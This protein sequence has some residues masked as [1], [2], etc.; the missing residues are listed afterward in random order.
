MGWVILR[1]VLFVTK[2]IFFFNV[3]KLGN[4]GDKSS[5][6]D[7]KYVTYKGLLCSKV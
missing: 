4:I 3:M 6:S 5:E 1:A 2:S 7:A